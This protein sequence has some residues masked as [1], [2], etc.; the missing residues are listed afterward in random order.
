MRRPTPPPSPSPGR[1]LEL[2][3]GLVG[4][5]QAV[6]AKGHNRQQ[7]GLADV[8]RSDGH[9]RNR[10]SAAH[11]RSRDPRRRPVGPARPT[12]SSASSA[13][14]RIGVPH[15]RAAAGRRRAPARRTP[16]A[17]R[18]RRRVAAVV[19]GV[20]G[21]R[22]RPVVLVDDRPHAPRARDRGRRGRDPPAGWSTTGAAACLVRCIPTPVV[23][24]SDPGSATTRSAIAATEAT[25]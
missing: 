21:D 15:R 16:P 19:H 10:T 12:H 20:G 17:P 4:P 13:A 6:D 22:R 3:V 9:E 7:D 1:V 5:D 2:L 23:S 8:P 11:A 18:W 25:T 14:S 24:P